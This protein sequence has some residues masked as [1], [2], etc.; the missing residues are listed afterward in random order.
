[1]AQSAVDYYKDYWVGEDQERTRR[2][3][4]SRLYDKVRDKIKTQ[5][6]W[7]V[8]DVAGGNGQFMRY[9][10][11]K[12]ADIL[13]ISSSG[14]EAAKRAGFNGIYG[15]IEKRF[16]IA[17]ESYD[18]VFLFEVL[19]HL[20]RPGK[21]LAEIHNVLKPQGVLYVGQPN[22]R[23]DGVHHVRRYYLAPLLN[24]LEKAG[25]VPE[26]VDHVP[27]YSMRDSIL[28]DIRMNPSW[29]R[30][31]VQSVNLCLSLLPWSLRYQMAKMVPD[32]FAL[33]LIIKAVKKR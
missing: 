13:D 17:E 27:A 24:D 21:T 9:L 22:M 26:W 29:V 10:G 33:M 23:A 16:P 4:Y 11:V 3:Y 8:L 32:R 30:K 25:F 28:S 12:N 19:E 20:H 1:M 7:R 15:D 18:A 6:G 14:L 31:A 5:D 2:Q